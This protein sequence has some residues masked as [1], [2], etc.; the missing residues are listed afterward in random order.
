MAKSKNSPVGRRGFL[1]GAAVGAAAALVA[2]PQIAK[3]QD[4]GAPRNATAS[5]P[6][7]IEL[8]RET[9]GWAEEGRYA[10]RVVTRPGSDF[11][12][13]VLKSLNIEYLGANPGSTFESLHESLIN[14]G[15]K[16]NTM[17]EFLTCTHEE[18]AVAMCH[19]YY[20]IE[21]KPMMALIHGDIG[22]QHAS[23]AI[24]NAYADR[25]P[26]FMIVGNHADGAE[27][28]AGVQSLHSAQDLGE[29]VRDYVKWDDEP[30]SLQHFADSTVRAYKIAMTPPMGPTLIV[31]NNEIQSHP[32]S[33][34]NLRIPKLTMTTPPAGDMAAVA[35]AAKMLVN[36]ERP[37]IVTQRH[38][39]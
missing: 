3:A 27:R 9:G 13:D 35:D 16:P 25:V 26:V 21:G 6:N 30:Y 24:Y 1:K 20:K 12:V 32:I 14:Y 11:M 34:T 33:E 31:A 10:S 28:A 19:G 39:R 36:A 23:M 37:M 2:K 7:T 15:P 29:L 5:T 38:A 4:Q 18:S 8:A 22:L 17:P